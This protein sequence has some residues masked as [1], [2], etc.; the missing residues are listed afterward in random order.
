MD[1][2]VVQVV[3]WQPGKN[4]IIDWKQSENPTAASL[5]VEASWE[6]KLPQL[7]YHALITLFCRCY[8]HP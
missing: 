7:V 2:S 4:L 3:E 6:G 5:M 1:A 8:T